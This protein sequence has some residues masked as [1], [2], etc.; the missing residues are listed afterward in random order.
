[1][2]SGVGALSSSTTEPAK[3]ARSKKPAILALTFSATVLGI[4]ANI[5]QL[6]VF[7]TR[8]ARAL[9][10]AV[11]LTGL[12]Y[13]VIKAWQFYF[14]EK[15][16]E[17]RAQLDDEAEKLTHVRS[18][19]QRCLEAIERISDRE[20]PLFSE[21]LEVTVCVGKDDDT[22]LIIE[23][24]VTTPE[25]LVTNR[26][27]R[28]IVPTYREQIA[29]LDALGFTVQRD[30]GQIT[31]I[32]LREQINKI[33]VWLV[34]DPPMSAKT[35]WRVEYRPKGLWRPLRERGFDE[36]GWD[37]R[38]Q[39]TNGT[40]S[41]FTSFTAVFKFP[42]GDQPPSVKERH[43]HGQLTKPEQKPD[44]TWEV[45]WRDEHPSGRRYDWDITQ[46]PRGTR[47]Q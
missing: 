44:R 7:P 46:P 34:F 25:P 16:R 3:S 11:V 12:L 47:Q 23:K 29:S 14:V 13:L 37:D 15:V 8:V 18:A 39:T 38:L 22:D 2:Q 28:P 32:P 24:R 21:T 45:T 41:A 30:G 42:E 6:G 35:E 31:F 43:G 36:L 26:T 5:T 20:K 10:I 33:K 9:L 1:M 27:M 17:L 4:V 40:P 19:H